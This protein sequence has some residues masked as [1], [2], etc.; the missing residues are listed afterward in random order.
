M[1]SAELCIRRLAES[2]SIEALTELIHRAYAPLGARGLNFTA[3]DQTPEVTAQRAAWGTCFMATVGSD[4]AGT[5]VVRGTHTDSVC[6][7]FNKPGVA[8]IH[9]FAVAPELQGKGIGSALLSAAETW[10]GENGFAE[11]LLDTAEPATELIDY[12]ERHGYHEVTTVQWPGKTYR[13][14]VMG[15]G[16]I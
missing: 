5:I 3:V 9:Q 12:Y 7:H 11:L 13:S 1:T 10:A 15:K 8:T 14:V 2:D 4:L 6:P 16:L